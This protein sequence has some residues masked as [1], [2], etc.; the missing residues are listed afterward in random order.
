MD[1]SKNVVR[2]ATMNHGYGE[3]PDEGSKRD[4]SVA[5]QSET[6]DLRFEIMYRIN[7]LGV[8]AT[9]LRDLLNHIKRL[10]E[11]PSGGR[12]RNVRGPMTRVQS[13]DGGDPREG[14]STPADFE[15][16]KDTSSGGSHRVLSR[17]SESSEIKE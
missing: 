6:E 14:S 12:D 13:G 10:A 7:D 8:P 2:R 1:L 16:R 15:A 3:A 5:D 17:R 11:R 9:V 4:P